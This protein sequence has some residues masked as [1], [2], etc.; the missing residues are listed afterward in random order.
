MAAPSYAAK[1]RDLALTIDLG[2]KRKG[3]GVKGQKA[4]RPLPRACWACAAL[5]SFKLPACSPVALVG[6]S[7]GATMGTKPGNLFDT[8]AWR[9]VQKIG[10]FPSYVPLIGLSARMMQ[11]Q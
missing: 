9:I 1:R 6:P 3:Q 10:C 5:V 11:Q 8:A 2:Q 4:F 7:R